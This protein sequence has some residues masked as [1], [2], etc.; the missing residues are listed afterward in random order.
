MR[1]GF[2]KHRRTPKN[3]S[4]F[5]K[6]FTQNGESAWGVMQAVA[7]KSLALDQFRPQHCLNFRPDPHEHG[8]F[9]PSRGPDLNGMSGRFAGNERESSG[10]D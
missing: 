3:M 10:R 9:R 7:V 4:T 8:S 2:R 6:W 5:M 1:N